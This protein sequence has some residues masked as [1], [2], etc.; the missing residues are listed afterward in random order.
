MSTKAA[1]STVR[2]AVRGN[3]GRLALGGIA[4]GAI[5]FGAGASTAAASADGCTYTSV[6]N[7]YV[8]GVVHGERLHVDTVDVVRGKYPGGTIRDY[9]A[10]VTVRSPRGTVWRYRS[11]THEGKTYV[12]A[13]RTLKIDG[14]FPD[15]SRLCGSFYEGGSLQD[16]VC[17]DIHD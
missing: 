5:A 9:H 16:T 3:L 12:R 13:Y 15:G 14:D 2:R 6:P 11:S 4:A 1:P 8:C 17:F 7:E 10:T